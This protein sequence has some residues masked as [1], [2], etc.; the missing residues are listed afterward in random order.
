MTWIICT[1]VVATPQR[2]TSVVAEPAY[3][4][5]RLLLD[6]PPQLRVVVGVVHAGEAEVLPDQQPE[7]ITQAVKGIVLVDAAAPYPEHDHL[8]IPSNGEQ[9]PVALLADRP[10]EHVG[11]QP[12][13][14]PGEDRNSVEEKFEVAPTLR[15]VA[16]V[17][18]D[19]AQ[20]HQIAPFVEQL[21]SVSE[22][23]D[24]LIARL[25]TEIMSPPQL[26]V[27]DPDR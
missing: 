3:L 18:G 9:R 10:D 25:P 14:T 11:R 8:P 16:A 19:G 22:P 1:L 6:L 7:L 15:I 5:S 21:L 12:G 20:T 26:S 4:V 24:H 13:R 23:D 27:L 17:Q 2:Q